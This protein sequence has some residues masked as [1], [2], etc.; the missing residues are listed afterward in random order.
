MAAPMVGLPSNAAQE[1]RPIMAQK[2][3]DRKQKPRGI[4]AQFHASGLTQRVFAEQEGVPLST[5]TYWLRRERLE[6][7][8]AGETALVAVAVGPEA[9]VTGFVVEFGEFRIEVPRNASVE[10]WQ[11]LRQAWTA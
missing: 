5:L 4:L 6:R 9:S 7:K 8:I 11:R 2:K 3:S 1:G 10:E